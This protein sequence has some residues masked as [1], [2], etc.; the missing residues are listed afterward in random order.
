MARKVCLPP[1]QK[2]F[3]VQWTDSALPSSSFSDSF[4][5]AFLTQL[6]ACGIGVSEDPAGATLNVTV[7]LTGSK[8]VL[9]ADYAVPE[10]TRRVQIVEI[11]R[12]ATP[13]SS[14]SSNAPRLRKELLWQQENPINSAMEWVDQASQGHFLF[15]LSEGF[16]L[17]R[18]LENHDWT[19]VD[20]TE[21]PLRAQRHRL[22]QGSF[23]YDDQ[24]PPALA[25]VLE[26]KIC[27]IL[28]ADRVSFSCRDTN[29]GGKV[30]SIASPCDEKVQVLA[31]GRGDY[32]QQDRITLAGPEVT[33][34]PL[35]DEEIRA[36][37]VELPGPVL[38]FASAA[39]GRSVTA[40]VRNLSTGIYE[41]YRI[42]TA[43]GG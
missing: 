29:L 24:Q 43:C 17:R 26:G 6:S 34:P 18:R 10:E 13:T 28:A 16:F 25:L 12:S 42:T 9:V 19:F 27:S 38:D 15:L 35:S 3:K 20:S 23:T 39:D 2:V 7:E 8:V 36:G 37:S 31:A 1:R 41:V 5:R 32:T 30:V 14:I 11:P 40:V 33:R 4:R 22:G 21:L